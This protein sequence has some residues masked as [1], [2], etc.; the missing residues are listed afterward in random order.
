[1]LQYPL[2]FRNAGT[3]CGVHNA[4]AP[5]AI[6]FFL[7]LFVGARGSMR[8]RFIVSNSTYVDGEQGT[9]IPTTYFLSASSWGQCDPGSFAA[10]VPLYVQGAS[11]AVGASSPFFTDLFRY[12]FDGLA[13]AGIVNPDRIDVEV[14]YRSPNYFAVFGASTTTDVGMGPIAGYLFQKTSSAACVFGFAQLS[15]IGEDFMPIQYLG[16]CAFDINEQTPFSA[17]ATQ[18]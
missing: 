13:I 12:S 15:A 4:V 1:M 16:P 18:V 2:T 10:P 9:T 14:P 11:T 3:R 6:G 5:N 8:H 17:W 7:E